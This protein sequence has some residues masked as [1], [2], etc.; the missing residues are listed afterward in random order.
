[1]G[2]I[3]KGV[4]TSLLEKEARVSTLPGLDLEPRRRKMV[5]WLLE[6]KLWRFV[7]HGLCAVWSIDQEK[8]FI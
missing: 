1:M 6:T 2:S 8:R 5:A 3:S 7:A 4:E